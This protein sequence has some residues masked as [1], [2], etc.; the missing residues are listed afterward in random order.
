MKRWI[1]AAV[2]AATLLVGPAGCG[3]GGDADTPTVDVP[4]IPKEVDI[5]LDGYPSPANVGILMAYERAYFEK[6]GLDV[7]IR[8]P[9]SRLR[10]LPYVVE[11][12][13]ALA[14]S[15][16]PQVVMAQEKGA[17][18]DTF[19]SLVSAPT[20]AL[21]WPKKA[22]INGIAGLKGKTVAITGL[23]FEESILEAALAQA[24]LT[25][26]D[27]E[28]IHADYELLPTLVQGSADAILGSWN[29]EGAEL[30]ARGLQP[31]ITRVE[32]LGI[33][34][35]DEFVLITRS[36][37]VDE[38]P[39]RI[40]GFMSALAR[41]TEAAIEDPE[42]AARVIAKQRGEKP[43]KALKA[44]VEATLPLLSESGSVSPDEE[45]VAW[46][47]EEGMLP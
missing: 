43:S 46:M 2:A 8:T 30:E 9:V 20:A 41:G 33:P 47:R 37:R 15:H 13:V 25:L 35:Y 3:G 26:G 17:P 5:T 14:V 36:E 27:V 18:V 21:I 32:D 23:P 28:V 31:V 39:G 44:A 29:V 11:R 1:V 22:G 10:P 19:G 45:L 24:G 38:E 12:Q 34:S 40:R 16:Q 4:P 42:A 6:V 7:W